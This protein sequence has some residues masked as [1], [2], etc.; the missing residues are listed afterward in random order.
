MARLFSDAD[1]RRVAVIGTCA[2]AS[3]AAALLCALACYLCTRSVK[4]ALQAGVVCGVCTMAGGA[5]LAVLFAW[6]DRRRR[7]RISEL[8]DRLGRILRDTSSVQTFEDYEEGELAVLANE[9]Q[10]ACTLLRDQAHALRRERD[11]LADS[12]ADISHQLRTPLMSMNLALGLLGRS[13]VASERRRA[14]L[15]ELRSTSDHMNWLV[16]SLLTLARA[17]AG[18]L[19]L[20]R[21]RVDVAELVEQAIEPLRIAFELADVALEVESPPPGACF[22]G[23][24]GWSREALANVLKN[25]LEHTPA[26]GTVRVAASRDVLAVRIAVADTGPG[27]SAT[28]LPHVFERFYKGEGSSNASFGIG[29]ALARC[30]VNAQGGSLTA[31][32]APA[33]GARFTFVFPQVAAV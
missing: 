18:T 6:I 5:A 22:E 27:I 31:A 7:A 11:A 10:K 23:D 33:G 14:L 30:L 26:G 13:D 29:L 3:L 1:R 9:L 16:T 8:A 24:A 15:R 12:L 4:L 20:T 17:D 25:C 2:L 19:Q 32:N 21:A 28:D